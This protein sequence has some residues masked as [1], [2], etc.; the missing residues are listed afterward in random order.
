MNRYWMAQIVSRYLSRLV[1]R[2]AYLVANSA[3]VGC[4]IER[5]CFNMCDF[6]VKLTIHIHLSE[7]IVV[8]RMI[9]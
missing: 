7:G 6:S 5:T 1:P 2:P 3:I 4:L 8:L 9:S